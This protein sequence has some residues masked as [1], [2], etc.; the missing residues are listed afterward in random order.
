MIEFQQ[1]GDDIIEIIGVGGRNSGI[2]SSHDFFIECLDVHGS[3]GG[4]LRC[5]LVEQTSER[6]HI[7]FGAIRLIFP[8]FGAGIVRRSGLGLRHI[9][10]DD[11]RHIEIPKFIDSIFCDENISSFK[12][13]MQYFLVM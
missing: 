9:I 1:R 6:P 2:D 11:F 12:I 8:N 5:H 3:E 4:S 13:S 7:T 10:F